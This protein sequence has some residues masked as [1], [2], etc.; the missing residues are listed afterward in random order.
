[1]PHNTPKLPLN[2]PSSAYSQNM[3]LDTTYSVCPTEIQYSYLESTED[4]IIYNYEI[5]TTIN[6]KVIALSKV[7]LDNAYKDFIECLE[8]Y[9]RPFR[10]LHIYIVKEYQKNRYPHWHCLLQTAQPIGTRSRNSVV[11][12]LNQNI[13]MT[14]FKDV[15]SVNS[16]WEYIHKDLYSNYDKLGEKHYEIYFFEMGLNKN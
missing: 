13:G 15:H 7:A 3:V 1:M 10:C 16:F 11:G 2:I 6:P 4:E 12:G 9:L 8:K 14:H 5:T